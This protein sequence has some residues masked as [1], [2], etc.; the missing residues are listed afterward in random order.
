MSLSYENSKLYKAI[1]TRLEQA[2]QPL[3][4]YDLFEVPAV[5]EHAPSLNRVSDYLGNMYR[6]GMLTRLPAPAGNGRARFVYQWNPDQPVKPVR[7]PRA[8]AQAAAPQAGAHPTPAPAP[9]RPAAPTRS[10][11]TVSELAGTVVLEFPDMIV[12]IKRKP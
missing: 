10:A 3:S 1:Q 4:C 2:Q 9:E 6:W 7:S 11:I 8:T 5:K 12:T